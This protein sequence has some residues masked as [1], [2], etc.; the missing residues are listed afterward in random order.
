[1]LVYDLFLKGDLPYCVDSDLSYYNTKWHEQGK[2]LS[3]ALILY[4]LIDGICK[5][6]FV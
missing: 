1:M 2:W 5:N 3:A 6:D 4:I